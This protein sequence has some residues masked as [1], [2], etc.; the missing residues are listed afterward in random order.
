MNEV[1]T[2]KFSFLFPFLEFNVYVS[3]AN[4]ERVDNLRK[5]EKHEMAQNRSKSKNTRKKWDVEGDERTV[6]IHFLYVIS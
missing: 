3:G 5:K 4:A 2:S 1:S 6:I